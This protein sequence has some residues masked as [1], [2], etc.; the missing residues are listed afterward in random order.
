MLKQYKI[1]EMK[2]NRFHESDL[3]NK[4]TLM[5]TLKINKL[6][7][8]VLFFVVFVGCVEDD[9]FNV[10]NTNIE[11]PILDGPVIQ[12]SDVL[13]RLVQEQVSEDDNNNPNPNNGLDYDSEITYQYPDDVIQ[14]M[15]GYVISTDEAGNFF[16]ELILQDDPTNP[17]VGIKVP[18]DVNPLFTRYDIGR[19]VYIRL[20]SLHAGISNGVLAVGFKE[21]NFISQIPFPLEIETIKRSAERAD[22]T[23]LPLPL[24]EFDNSKTNLFINISDVQFNRTQALIE[25]LTFSSE[26][27]DEFDGE[28]TLESCTSSASRVFSTSTFADFSG[29]KLPKGRGSIDAILSKNFFGDEFN[30]VINT[31]EAINFGD[32]ENRCDPDFLECT[33]ASGGGSAIFSEDFETFGSFTSEGW[34]NVNVGGGGTEWVEGSFSGNAYAQITGFNANDDNIDVWL[35]TPTI[36]M[37]S[38]SGEEFSFDIQVNF[39]NGTIL[40]VWVSQ[41][42]TG[43]PTTATWQAIDVSIPIGPG[44]GFGSFESV[45]PVN[46]SCLDGD[47]NI[48]FFYEGADPGP[49]TRY[50]VDNVEVTGN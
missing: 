46:L 20:T 48:G 26:G 29:L 38:T 15:E 18:I 22:L 37:D 25:E 50:H 12:I 6:I 49:T 1:Q 34:V 44:G 28:R 17:T 9:D 35:V 7:P 5:K 32:I 14:Y 2:S 16:E 33:E 30:V 31:P 42:F 10:P 11:E 8:L 13:N 3:E 45:S 41:D 36:N 24:D 19:K 21:G 27:S 39:D 4:T 43:D 23:P 40:T 47:I